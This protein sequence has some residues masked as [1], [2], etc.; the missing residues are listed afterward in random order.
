MTVSFVGHGGLG[1]GSS[2]GVGDREQGTGHRE[3][4][5]GERGKG[6]GERGKGKGKRSM[7][8]PTS[9]PCFPVIRTPSSAIPNACERDLIWQQ[10]RRSSPDFPLVNARP[11]ED[12]ASRIIDRSPSNPPRPSSPPQPAAGPVPSMDS[13]SLSLSLFL[14]PIML[15]TTELLPS[16]ILTVSTV[17]SQ[18]MEQLTASLDVFA[19]SNGT[20]LLAGHPPVPVVNHACSL[21]LP[22]SS[23]LFRCLL[24]LLCSAYPAR[25]PRSF[26]L[27]A[28]I[29][30]ICTIHSFPS[31]PSRGLSNGRFNPFTHS[32]KE[33]PFEI[34]HL[35][36]RNKPLNI[37]SSSA[38]SFKNRPP[39]TDNST[40]RLL[41]A[42]AVA[43][44]N[45][46]SHTASNQILS[47]VRSDCLEDSSA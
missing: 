25:L 44:S 30:P 1:G 8:P 37:N 35:V 38:S 34:Y 13:I 36:S 20:L 9:S 27:I 26:L 2:R 15:S 12:G 28:P 47:L 11:C 41:P 31:V 10:D 42:P 23:H 39:F 17:C 32:F 29:F 14:D 18:S 33:H 46:Q 6:K 24:T 7:V 19:A 4:G 40:Q 43:R 21:S 3:Q 22:L 16:A 5:K 45:L